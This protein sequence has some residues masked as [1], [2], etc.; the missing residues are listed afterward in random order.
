MGKRRLTG[1]HALDTDPDPGPAPKTGL[2]LWTID[3]HF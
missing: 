3:R 1:A 2:L